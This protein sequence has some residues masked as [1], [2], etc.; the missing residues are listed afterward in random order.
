MAVRRP[1]VPTGPSVSAIRARYEQPTERLTTLRHVQS[2]LVSLSGLIG[3][4]ILNQ[5]GGEIGPVVDVVAR[6]DGA[7]RTHPSPAC[8]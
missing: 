5:A 7:T 4:P 1:A 8:S 2:A 3:R 6:W